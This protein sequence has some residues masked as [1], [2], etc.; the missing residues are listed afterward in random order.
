MSLARRMKCPNLEINLSFDTPEKA[1]A[2]RLQE[3]LA[4]G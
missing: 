3:L 2:F 4:H 1:A